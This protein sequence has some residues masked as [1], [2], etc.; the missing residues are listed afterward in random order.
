[1]LSTKSLVELWQKKKRILTDWA[2]E[3]APT[4]KKQCLYYYHIFKASDD[5]NLLMRI[6]P[7]KELFRVSS[8]RT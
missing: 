7:D 6:W 2:T 5:N 1:M 3:I 4:S 8:F